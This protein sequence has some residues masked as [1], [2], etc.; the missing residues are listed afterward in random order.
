MIILR[1][2]NNTRHTFNPKE[3]KE[4]MSEGYELIKGAKEMSNANKKEKSK[5]RKAKKK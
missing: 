3:A 5:A 2:A 4:W 1:K